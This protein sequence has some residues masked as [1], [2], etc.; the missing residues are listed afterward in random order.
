MLRSSLK[1]VIRTL[2]NGILSMLFAY[3]NRDKNR[4][5]KCSVL[6]I[7]KQLLV[8]VYVYAKCMVEMSFLEAQFSESSCTGW[9][10]PFPKSSLS[11]PWAYRP[12]D[13]DAVGIARQRASSPH[14]SHFLQRQCCIHELINL[15]QRTKNNRSD[16]LVYCISCLRANSCSFN[17]GKL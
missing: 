8:T 17:L 11:T 4:K 1:I 3:I 12:I 14:N 13:L 9:G 16:L 2:K 5:A 6:L 7:A 10:H 15:R